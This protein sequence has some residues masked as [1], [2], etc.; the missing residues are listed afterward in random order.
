M[1]KTIL[2]VADKKKIVKRIIDK[3]ATLEQISEEVN[4]PVTTIISWIRKYCKTENIPV[5]DFLVAEFNKFQNK[6]SPKPTLESQA[7]SLLMLEGL[8]TKQVAKRLGIGQSVVERYQKNYLKNNSAEIK[9]IKS[10]ETLKNPKLARYTVDFKKQVAKDYVVNKI[11]AKDLIVKYNISISSV[12]RWVALYGSQFNEICVNNTTST[13]AIEI[14]TQINKSNSKVSD[15]AHIE[16][17]V[18]SHLKNE[19]DRL[20]DENLRLKQIITLLVNV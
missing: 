13:D 20:K 1:E 15:I 19:I 10:N 2:H 11:D 5:P 14:D 8:T 18:I 6:H 3:E 17:V 7:I 16:N 9:E 4:E 12:R